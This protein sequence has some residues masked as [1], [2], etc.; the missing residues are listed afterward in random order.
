MRSTKLLFFAFTFLF[1]I[2]ATLVSA[3]APL[4]QNSLDLSAP[5]AIAA[6]LEVDNDGDS[7]TYLPGATCISGIPNDCSLRQ[8]ILV[9]NAT[10]GSDIIRFDMTLYPNGMTIRPNSQLP[11]ITRP[12][13]I[14]GVTGTG[15]NCPS[16]NDPAELSVTLDGRNLSGTDRGVWL[17]YYEDSSNPFNNTNSNGST[18]RGLN[19]INFPG[20]GILIDSTDDH[21]I[22][23]NH[24]GLANGDTVAGNLIGVTISSSF[25][26][27]NTIGGASIP[28]RNV[29]SGNTADGIRITGDATLVEGNYIGV[30]KTG[31]QA[32]GNGEDGIENEGINNTIRGNLI[33]NNMVGVESSV[34]THVTTIQDN[35]VLFNQSIG[36]ISATNNGTISGNEVYY[37][38]WPLPDA[39]LDGDGIVATGYYVQVSDND[40]QFNSGRGINVPG[41][42]AVIRGN[43]VGNLANSEGNGGEGIYVTGDSAVI[44]DNIVSMN[45]GGGIYVEANGAWIAGNLVGTDETGT[46]AKG[47]GGTGVAVIGDTATLFDNVISDNNYGIILVGDS[48][49]IQGNKIGASADGNTPMGNAGYGLF[50]R[51]SGVTIGGPTPSTD[52]NIIADSA[53]AGIWLWT[54][55][56]TGAVVQGNYIG[57][58]ADGNTPMGNGGNGVQISD[59]ASDNRVGQAGAENVIA[60]NGTNGI[61][62]I[63]NASVRNDLRDNIIDNNGALGIDLR[64]SGEDVGEATPNDFNDP[65]PGPNG[66]QNFMNLTSAESSGRVQ[67]VLRGPNGLYTISIYQLDTC[68]SSGYGEG[69]SNRIRLILAATVSGGVYNYDEVLSPAPPLGSYLVTQVTDAD[70]NTSEFSECR[71]VAEAGFVVDSTLDFGDNNPGDGNCESVGTGVCTLRAAIEEVNAL[72]GGP[73]TI[74]FDFGALNLV[75]TIELNSGL[76]A[77]T[78]PV[79]I[80]ASTMIN[81]TCPTG[82][83]AANHRLVLDGTNA[84]DD[85]LTLA[86]TA[87][88]STIRGFEIRNFPGDG[89]QVDGDDNV[90][91]CNTLTNNFQGVNVNGNSNRVGGTARS[92][93][94]VIIN[95]GRWGLRLGNSATLNKVQGNFIGVAG[96]GATAAGNGDSGVFLSGGGSNRIGGSVG[97]AAN[98]ISANGLHGIEID[99]GAGNNRIWGNLIGLDVS[100]STALGNTGSGIYVNSAN[101]NEIGGDSDSKRNVIAAN[102]GNGIFLNSSSNVI[103]RNYIGTDINGLIDLGNSSMGIRVIDGDTNL[104]GG[105]DPADANLISG[106]GDSGVYVAGNAVATTIRHN[107]IGVTAGGNALGN[108]LNGVHLTGQVSQADV[109][110]NTIAYNGKDG[111]AV[112]ETVILSDFAG[113][114]IY[115]NGELGIDLNNDD[116]VNLNDTGDGDGG[117]N[118]LMNFPVILEALADSNTVSI[119]LNSLEP[120]SYRIH[121]YRNRSCDSSGYGEGERYLGSFDV[122]TISGNPFVLD[123]AV[124]PRNFNAGDKITATATPLTS[125]ITDGTSEF[126]AC[127]T[128]T[129]APTPQLTWGDQN[130]GFVVNATAG[131]QPV[132]DRVQAT[133]AQN[134]WANCPTCTP[135]TLHLVPFRNTAVYLGNTTDPDQ[136]GNWLGTLEAGGGGA[137]ADATFAALR[138]FG[139]NLDADNAAV[140]D[141]V[142]FSDSVPAGNRRAFG[143]LL[144]QLILR[145]I[146]THNV[147]PTLC[148]D[149][150]LPDFAM[151]YLSLLSG[152][153]FHLPDSVSEYPTD[154]QMAMNLA[155]AQ[156]V[157]G[158]FRGQLDNSTATFPIEV[159]SSVTTLGVDYQIQCLTCTYTTAVSL[160]DMVMTAKD[161]T[162]ELLDPNGNVVDATTPGY[163]QWRT[164]TRAMQMLFES[165]SA[166]DAGTWQLRVSGTG[167]YAINVFGDSS[168]HMTTLGRHTARANTL[169]PVSALLTAEA[170]ASC[171]GGCDPITATLTLVGL[172]NT[173]TFPVTLS[174]DGVTGSVYSGSVTVTTPGLYRLM[175]AGELENGTQ[176][177]RVDPTPI[178]VRAHGVSGSGNTAVTPGTL[179][180]ISFE[181]VNDGATGA[182]A[183]TTFDLELV[184][185]L[186]WTATA[187][188][189]DSVTLAVGESVVYTVDTAVPTDAEIGLIEESVFVAVPQDDLSASV[190]YTVQTTVMS[191]FRIF[192]PAIVR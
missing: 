185:E 101:S 161:I 99:A 3:A 176:F 157:L 158:T 151:D 71:Q 120:R 76:P 145:G 89:I 191:E 17:G 45:A 53:S 18:I 63:D 174:G 44:E 35:Q 123:A 57:V 143:Y 184:S 137:C 87:S 37:T 144:D 127:F 190:S 118:G 138:D 126:S 50:V 148:S 103:Q 42:G 132:I 84:P 168:V 131:M 60:N 189:P 159:D 107:D 5:S 74:S 177:M 64:G 31:L 56:T 175:A 11:E 26:D 100:G 183:P 4:P 167:Q 129:G 146:Q 139:L 178:R 150:N 86:S 69:G 77:I 140:S 162:V 70:G 6:V 10:S 48:H 141:A 72:G 192:L 110:N 94:N 54:D 62:V 149:G 98:V 66:L 58:G 13:E 142:V 24:I 116:V 105:D 119:M 169:F 12:V 2:G 136:F 20:S 9:A 33:A 186:G 171:P 7:S 152:G 125:P 81:A 25:A 1:V 130:V 91:A 22:V 155:L 59:G 108:T 82:T 68:D 164:P 187:A 41:I 19:I 106:N 79:F 117:G 55:D 113:N 83:S 46:T 32:R 90:I 67:G 92:E 28:D 47:N 188:I 23:C 134:P 154:A 156:D 78:T 133:W 163:Q 104:I 8:A 14:D 112:F 51:G 97:F 65:D 15:G 38:N 160:A 16:A 173:E 49:T 102:G 128:A 147:G 124:L 73:Y 122:S 95:S 109:R 27:D 115:D 181:L 40:V 96:D 179:R 121:V 80:D 166:A 39:A 93:R 153:T 43:T 61:S 30:D 34:A 165:V 182:T 111:I 114:E 36:I 29:I 85:G 172:D 75:R 52:R 21:T 170:G 180:S 135:D 88:G